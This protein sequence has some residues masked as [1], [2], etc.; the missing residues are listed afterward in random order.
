M[1]TVT[2]QTF[3][4]PGPHLYAAGRKMVA[5]QPVVPIAQGV[6]IGVAILSYHGNVSFGVTGGYDTVPDV[7]RLCRSIESGIDDLHDQAQPLDQCEVTLSS[8]P[9]PVPAR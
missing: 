7:A 6:R 4:G 9:A 8:G 2:T 5:Y 1:G 3:G